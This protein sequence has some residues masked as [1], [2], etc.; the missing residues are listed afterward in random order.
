MQNECPTYTQLLSMEHFVESS[1]GFQEINYGTPLPKQEN[2]T[3]FSRHIYSNPSLLQ[4]QQN[5]GRV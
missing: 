3:F 1:Q 5:F 4:H 2:T